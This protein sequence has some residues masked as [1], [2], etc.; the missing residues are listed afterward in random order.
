MVRLIIINALFRIHYNNIYIDYDISCAECSGP[1][2]FEK[3]MGIPSKIYFKCKVY[4]GAS[5]LV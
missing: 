1:S 3:H 2:C 4:H 5:V